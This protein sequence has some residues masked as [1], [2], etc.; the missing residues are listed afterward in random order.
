MYDFNI[1]YHLFKDGSWVSD[2][3]T[4]KDDAEK[5]FQSLSNLGY[6]P[7]RKYKH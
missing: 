6:K 4:D 2:G 3:F 1:E 5:H 7:K